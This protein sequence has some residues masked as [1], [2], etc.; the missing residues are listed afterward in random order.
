MRA[1]PIFSKHETRDA[2]ADYATKLMLGALEVAIEDRGRASMMVSGGSTP[3]PVFDR[4]CKTPL[5]W[6]RVTVGLV[7]ER[8][9]E[10]SHE[11]S[12]ERLVRERLLT[13]LAGAAGLLPMKTGE[14][15]AAEAVADRAIAYGVHCG[16]LDLIMLGMGNDGHT[17]SWFPRSRG[18]EEAFSHPTNQS[19]TAIDA[20]GCDVAGAYTD[21]LTLTGNAVKAAKCAVLVIFGDEKRAVYE[22]ALEADKFDM[23]VRHAIDLL[24]SKLTIIWAP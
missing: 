9:V 10:P 19:V 14:Q 23:P 4:L 5:S 12:N 21:R 16:S 18:L 24:G 3:G 22:S 6:D 11:A 15:K 13:G 17:A 8:W 20:T 7:D 1:D 2:A